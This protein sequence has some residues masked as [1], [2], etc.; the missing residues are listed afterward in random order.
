MGLWLAA[1]EKPKQVLQAQDEASQTK[2]QGRTR[3]RHLAAQPVNPGRIFLPWFQCVRI[4]NPPNIPHESTAE[5]KRAELSLPSTS[6]SRLVSHREQLVE[7]IDL[8]Q[9]R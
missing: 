9:Q 2:A 4:S 7:E 8:P 3:Q 6:S 5:P 1:E